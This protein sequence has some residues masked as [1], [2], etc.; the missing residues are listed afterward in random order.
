MNT[1]CQLA[2]FDHGNTAGSI[3]RRLTFLGC[4]TDKM[5]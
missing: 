2:V 3:D 1:Q 4:M 5:L